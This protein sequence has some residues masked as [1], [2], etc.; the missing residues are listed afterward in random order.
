M[1]KIW[2]NLMEF[3]KFSCHQMPDRSFFIKGY[4]FPIC[5][6][7]TGVLISFFLTVIIFF[8]RNISFTSNIFMFFIMLIDWLLQFFNI[9]QSTNNR[10]F[11]T[12][13]I[14]G[15][16]FNMINLKLIKWFLNKSNI[17]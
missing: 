2:I 17:N 12:G 10:R 11:I 1:D 3:F 7:C 4:Q 9:K 13:L 8:K 6:R 14:G 16:G 15:L 5:A